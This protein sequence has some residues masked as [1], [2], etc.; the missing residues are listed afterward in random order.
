MHLKEAKGIENAFERV[1]KPAAFEYKYDGFRI[2]VHKKDKEIILFTRR[3]E[4]VTKQFPE[5]VKYVKE[6]IKGKSFI[7]DTEAVGFDPK[8]KKY[9]PFQS[10]S[11]RIKRKYDIDKMAKDFPVEMNVFDAVYF[12]GKNLMAE[13]FEK[14]RQLIEKIVK[15]EK[16]KIVVAKQLVTSDAKE[17]DKFYNES[18][19]Q[20]EEGVMVKNL[21]GIYK[22]GSRVGYGVKVK[23]VMETLDLVVVAADWGEGKRG[24]WLSSY[25]VACR[26]EETGELLEIG[27]VGTGFKELETEE[28]VTFAQMTELLKPLIKSEKGK[29]VFV[30]PKIVIELRYEEIQKSPTYSSGYA[31]RFPRLVK[32]REDKAVDEASTIAMVKE[33]YKEQK[34]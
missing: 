33:L 18:L 4:N 22:P 14:R 24:K 27:K 9:L 31:L 7:L 20:G 17:A 29:K 10:M 12:E 6:H 5:V 13:P 30:R 23:P 26:D 11:Q 15:P 34:K 1:G 3:L 25:T 32:L 8:T 19:S 28:G 21:K 2:Q 16:R